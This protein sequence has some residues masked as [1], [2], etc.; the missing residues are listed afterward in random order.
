MPRRC[1]LSETGDPR[2]RLLRAGTVAA[3]AAAFIL[4]APMAH[5][6]GRGIE[7]SSTACADLAAKDVERLLLLELGA[8]AREPG[9]PLRIELSCEGDE[10]RAIAD[11][12]I[13]NK[14]LERR[15][16]LAAS[17]VPVSERARVVAV[18]VSQLFLTSWSELL[19]QPTPG[20]SLLPPRPP[21]AA[22]LGLASRSLVVPKRI[23]RIG[24][25]V[26]ADVRALATPIALGTARVF[27]TLELRR[28]HAGASIGVE[29]GSATRDA[30]RLTA[31]IA[32]LAVD[33]SLP[34]AHSGR[35]G[36]NAGMRGGAS[37][38][39]VQATG[40]ASGRAG[41]SAGG[42]VAHAGFA[43]VPHAALGAFDLGLE[44]S[45]GYA[46]PKATARVAA[47]EPLALAGFF[48][49]ATLLVSYG[50]EGP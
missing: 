23:W 28:V 48:S 32:D 11:D 8:V 10:L 45:A 38:I 34:L 2:V 36:L 13:T 5:A 15:V 24:V 43:V 1:A 16:P 19:L 47:E 33:I 20:P 31:S 18:L 7:V 46:Y 49:G 3:A 12:P 21:A 25:G 41:G 27:T 44:L 37:A 26:G 9:E 29:R 40:A 17:R 4:R 6:A 50:S 42:V 39:D 22:A 14:R 35:F 30:G